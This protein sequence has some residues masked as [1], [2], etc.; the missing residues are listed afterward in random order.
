MK[1]AVEKML[2]K[3]GT[4]VLVLQLPADLQPL[5][6]DMRAQCTVVA[7]AAAA[8]NVDAALVFA[9]QQA[10]IDQLAPQ[11]AAVAA[12]DAAVWFAYPK[13]TSKMYRCDFNRDTGWAPLHA[14]GFE[15]VRQIAIDDDWS[16]LRFRRVEYI[17]QMT[18][19]TRRATQPQA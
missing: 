5:L 17:K 9:T 10:E 8:D 14:L 15:P 12:G 7:D 13:G 6:A 1:S 11:V 2:L 4:V 18:R 16:A 3:P 19:A